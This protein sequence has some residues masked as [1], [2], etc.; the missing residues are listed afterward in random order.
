[1]PIDQQMLDEELRRVRESGFGFNPM[2]GKAAAQKKMREERKREEREPTPDPTALDI[3]AGRQFGF[4][5]NVER[6]GILPYPRGALTKG[7]K[8]DWSD[9]IAPQIVYEAA[10]AYALPGYAAQGGDYTPEEVVNMAGTVAG[11]G[12][13]LGRA[14][15]GSLGMMIGPRSK[16]WDRVAEDLAKK[17]ENEGKDKTEIWEAT[18]TMRAPDGNWRQEIPDTEMQ[19]TL[20][21]I[22]S[23]QIEAH[24]KRYQKAKDK[25]ATPEELSAIEQQRKKAFAKAVLN[26]GGTASDFVSHPLLFQAYPE[27]S[28]LAWK[29]LKPTSRQFNAPKTTSGFYDPNLK[30]IVINTD[31]DDKRSTALHELQHAIQNIEGWQGGSSPEYMATKLAERDVFKDAIQKR[32]ELLNSLSPTSILR[33]SVEKSLQEAK[34]NFK[35]YELL[36]GLDPYGAYRRVLGEEEARMVEKRRKLTKEELKA[37]PPFRDYEFEPSE[38]IYIGQGGDSV[39]YS[40]DKSALSKPLTKRQFEKQFAQHID[41]RGRENKSQEEN[42]RAIL[43]EGFRRGFGPN[44][45]PPYAG[46]APLNIM[47][48]RFQPRSGDVVY[49]APKSAWQ[50][51]PNGMQ[52]IEG[53]KP[54]PQNIVRVQDPNQSMYEAYLANLKAEGAL[55]KA[56]K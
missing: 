42:M 11:G 54:E 36:E 14:P 29:Q 13:A 21:T 31:A 48:E 34:E 15:V 19:Y 32:Q 38:H 55:P 27:L 12:M 41:I 7:S 9:W 56:T 3:Q 8:V 20:N 53:W 17:L 35:P 49:L 10:K 43:E 52:I 39:S 30:R 44:A 24:N 6:L 46:G 40:N 16:L 33:P 1:M 18:K 47:S 26:L 2:A 23:K 37:R 50:K 22:R 51:T 5:P 4:D 28:S 45:V 25:A